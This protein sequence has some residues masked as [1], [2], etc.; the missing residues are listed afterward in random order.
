MSSRIK[1]FIS[2]VVGVLIALA[3]LRDSRLSKI[4]IA[5]TGVDMV[6]R[7]THV[8]MF[9][10]GRALKLIKNGVSITNSINPLTLTKN[11][12]L[13]VLDCSAPPPIRLIVEH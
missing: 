11:I 7:F 1:T 3:S 4:L 6:N 9:R 5:L 13:M 10:G 8:Y 12:T 2:I